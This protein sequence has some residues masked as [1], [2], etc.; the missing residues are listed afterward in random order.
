MPPQIRN[1]PISL[2]V[3]L[4][5]MHRSRMPV[6]KMQQRAHN[7][8]ISL[9][10]TRRSIRNRRTCEAQRQR[11]TRSRPISLARQ[12]EPRPAITSPLILL[13]RRRR[14]IRNPH[15]YGVVRL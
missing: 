6:D 7:Q 9:D 5:L 13:A 2:G 1:R 3:M 4:H 14:L 11:A 15:I 10:A 8:P 12:A